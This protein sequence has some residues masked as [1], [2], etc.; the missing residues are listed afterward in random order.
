MTVGDIFGGHN[1]G[2]PEEHIGSSSTLF[3]DH[4]TSPKKFIIDT[5]KYMKFILHEDYTFKN[6]D[7]NE[8]DKS[9]DPGNDDKV[10]R[11][12]AKKTQTEY[13]PEAQEKDNKTDILL[14]FP[15][16]DQLKNNK[17][18][19]YVFGEDF[20]S[21][22]DFAKQQINAD[23]NFI[24]TP[25]GKLDLTYTDRSSELKVF[26]SKNGASL[27]LIGVFSVNDY[28]KYNFAKKQAEKNMSHG[29]SRGVLVPYN[30]YGE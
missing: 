11:I 26:D 1:Y 5:D 9:L 21:I 16:V 18:L 27:Y 20:R 2:D 7:K 14:Y 10:P 12:R 3:I 24:E 8:V 17:D 29:A 22:E 15:K 25:Y 4:H 28:V 6:I 19:V 23:G 13:P 30:F